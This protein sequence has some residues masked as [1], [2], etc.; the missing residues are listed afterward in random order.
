MVKVLGCGVWL[1][2]FFYM[3]ARS[4]QKYT[5]N[6]FTSADDPFFQGGRTEHLSVTTRLDYYYYLQKHN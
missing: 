2:Q 1:W 6:L 4:T 5:K 3:R